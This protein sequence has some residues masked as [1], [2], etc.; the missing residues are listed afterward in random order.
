MRGHFEQF[1]L[2]DFLD[3]FQ[4]GSSEGLHREVI[5]SRVELVFGDSSKFDL[6]INEARG[7]NEQS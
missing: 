1:H 5:S 6:S 2:F 7:L 4:Q 3:G